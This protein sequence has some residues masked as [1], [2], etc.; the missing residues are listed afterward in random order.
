MSCETRLGC[1]ITHAQIQRIQYKLPFTLSNKKI[2]L[3]KH[4]Q[5]LGL[6]NTISIYSLA[7]AM[8]NMHACLCTL[9]YQSRLFTIQL[10]SIWSRYRPYS[11]IALL[12]AVHTV[13]EVSQCYFFHSHFY[14]AAWWWWI[15]IYSHYVPY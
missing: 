6:C 15:Q 4:M 1:R 7:M 13:H 14:C 11:L 10:L 5:S 2:E 12:N 8:Y 9:L 3:F